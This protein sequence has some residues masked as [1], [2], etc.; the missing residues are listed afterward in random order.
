MTGNS[1]EKLARALRG[2]YG[3]CGVFDLCDRL[4]VA[5]V[6]QELPPRVNGF[7]VR[8]GSRCVIVISGLVPPERRDYVCA[9][10]LGHVLLHPGLNEQTMADL[11]D[12]CTKK[13]E[14]EADCF[15]ACLLLEERMKE[16]SR[17]CESL[18]AN[19]VSQLSGVPRRVVELW[20]CACAGD[21]VAG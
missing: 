8:F 20:F 5:V 2:R 1:A 11:T 7:Y 14:N 13:L 4:G 6:Y 15:A 3:P 10:E 17:C 16:W 12:L 21:S 18:T 9:H 19:Q